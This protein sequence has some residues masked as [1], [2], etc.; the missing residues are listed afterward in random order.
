MNFLKKRYAFKN[1]LKRLLAFFFDGTGTLLCLPFRLIRKPH[2]A[3][4]IRKILAVRLDHIGDV[5]M[6]R[7]SLAALKKKFPEAEIDLLVS[8]GVKDLFIDQPEI[9]EVIPFE[10]SWFSSHSSFRGEIAEFNRMR[11]ILKAGGYNLGIDFRGDLRNI[12]LMTFAGIPYRLGYGRTGGSFLLSET[13][14]YPS[15]EHQVKV[16][17][18]LLESLGINGEPE[19]TPFDYSEEQ[20]ENFRTRFP[21]IALTGEGR[22]IV[23]HPTA[24]YPSKQWPL[25]KYW[26]LIQRMAYENRGQMIL[27]GSEKDRYSEDVFESLPE[28]VIDLRGKTSLRDL[29]VLFDLCDFYIGNDSGPAH[30]AALQG[31][32]VLVIAGGTNRLSEW[33]PWTSRFFAAS[34]PVPCSPCEAREC[35]LK[36]HDCMMKITVDEVYE[37]MKTMMSSTLELAERI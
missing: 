10:N 7:P 17:L 29:P 25:I 9:H 30:L 4:N 31:L 28:K 37:K 21:H 34:H 36:H 15:D 32:P 3:E 13:V 35:P 20:K 33:H 1:P 26:Q 11:K 6:T 23:I 14:P 18:R 27:I 24:G 12:L 2:S 8:A 19:G 16:N 22:K 5:A